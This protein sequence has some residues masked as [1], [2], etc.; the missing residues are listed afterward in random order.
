[1]LWNIKICVNTYVQI[2]HK[3]WNKCSLLCQT[4]KPT[5]I[6][7]WLSKTMGQ[8][9]GHKWQI[10]GTKH[11]KDWTICRKVWNS[12]VEYPGKE[13]KPDIIVNPVVTLSNLL[14]RLIQ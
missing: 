5:I 8:L 10:Y 9:T 13:S 4:Y 14:P 2:Y 11:H 6:S 3:Q 12:P 1:M 7:N